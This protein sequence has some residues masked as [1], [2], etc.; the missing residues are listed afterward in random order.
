MKRLARFL[1][2]AVAAAALAGC[3]TSYKLENDVQTFA[4]TP[5]LPT[6]ATYRFERL[7]SQQVHPGQTALEALAEPALQKAGLQRDDTNPRMSVQV[8]ARTERT[9]SPFSEPWAWGRG[10]G[11]W[12]ST[13]GHSGFHRPWGS[14]YWDSPWYHREVAVVVREIGTNRVLYETHVVNDGLWSDNRSVLP[15][16]FEAAMQGFPNPPGGLRRVDIVVGGAN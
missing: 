1:A 4:S 10:Y 14:W 12:G 13:W 8:L 16:M 3:A 6:P 2:L 7:P 9:L 15:G 5:A 11:Y